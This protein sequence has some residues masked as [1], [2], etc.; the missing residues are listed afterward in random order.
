MN[1]VSDLKRREDAHAVPKLAR[2][3]IR[4][5]VEFRTKCFG[6][7]MRLRIAFSLARPHITARA[8][9]FATIRSPATYNESDRADGWAAL[10][11]IPFDLA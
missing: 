5:F 9:Q 1:K 11:K 4:I 6:S 3:E 10:A 8:G 7:A 2:N